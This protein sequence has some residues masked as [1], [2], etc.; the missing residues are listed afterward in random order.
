MS[1]CNRQRLLQKNDNWS[2]CREQVTCHAQHWLMHQQPT[3]IPKF[4][5]PSLRGDAKIVREGQRD[6]KSAVSQCL[7]GTSET[8][9]MNSYQHGYLDKMGTR[10]TSLD[11]LKWKAESS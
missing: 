10:M 2:E 3:L 11:M 1:A 6:G 9:R 5:D 4:K 8:T 7:L